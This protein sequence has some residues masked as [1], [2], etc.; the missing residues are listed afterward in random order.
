MELFKAPADQLL[1]TFTVSKDDM[2]RVKD[3]MA[4]EAARRGVALPRCTSLVAT[5]GF[6]W[7]CYLRAKDDTKATATSAARTSGDRAR[8][9][10]LFPVDHRSRM[11]P[12]LPD[13]Y[14]GNCFGPALCLASRYSHSCANACRTSSKAFTPPLPRRTSSVVLTAEQPAAQISA[15]TSSTVTRCGG[16]GGEGGAEQVRVVP[17]EGG[18][19]G[20][21]LPLWRTFCPLHRYAEKHACGFDFKTAGRE[22]IAKNNRSSWQP[23]ISK[24]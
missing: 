15:A 8:A 20:V 17:Q 16:A 3:A 7:S 18:A 2:Q 13:K 24:I 12:P 9:C 14:L 19:A 11:K 5:L 21:S 1:A 23:K 22:K 10:L 6:V 4:A